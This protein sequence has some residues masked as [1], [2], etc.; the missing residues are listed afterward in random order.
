[1]RATRDLHARA[2]TSSAAAARLEA[3]EGSPELGFCGGDVAIGSRIRGD[4]SSGFR[5]RK[6]RWVLSLTSCLILSTSEMPV[7]CHGHWTLN[8]CIFPY[9]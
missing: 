6:F 4:G 7:R 2:D 9:T 5:A 3:S 1:M 8:Y